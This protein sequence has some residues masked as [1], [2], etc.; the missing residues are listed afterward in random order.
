M[1]KRLI[2]KGADFSDNAIPIEYETD[3][4]LNNTTVDRESISF[5]PAYVAG[6]TAFWGAYATTAAVGKTINIVR[7]E[8]KSISQQTLPL[9]MSL[10]K[11]KVGDT[12]ATDF[13]VIKNF[14]IT[15]DDVAAGYKEIEIDDTTLA[16]VNETI[17]PCLIDNSTTVYSPIGMI[18]D[19]NAY[20]MRLDANHT[21]CAISQG[22]EVCISLG[23]KH[24]L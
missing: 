6:A 19:S 7:L 8:L 17:A 11:V 5:N 10:C 14:T 23:N 21:T 2:I 20:Y 3:W 22:Y 24:E 4:Y 15:S 9:T 12:T 18:S 1:G 13:T 16:S